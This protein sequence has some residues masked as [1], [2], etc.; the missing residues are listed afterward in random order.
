MMFLGD[1]VIL[2]FF[3]EAFYQLLRYL[4]LLICATQSLSKKPIFPIMGFLVN[5]VSLSTGLC[6]SQ[7]FLC[8]CYVINF[9]YLSWQ[10]HNWNV[11][12]DSTLTL[13]ISPQNTHTSLEY[14][15]TFRHCTSSRR[16]SP[17]L[18]HRQLSDLHKRRARPRSRFSIFSKSR[19]CGVM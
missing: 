4:H 13:W 1:K 8:C 19:N 5:S 18:F 11:M 6:V 7:A 3:C 17:K 15:C 14:I 16:E 9:L 12:L 10:Y 2:M